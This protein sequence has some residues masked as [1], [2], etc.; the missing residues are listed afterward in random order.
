[1][2]RLFIKILVEFTSLTIWTKS[3][4]WTFAWVDPQVRQNN[5]RNISNSDNSNNNDSNNILRSIMPLR[6]F[7]WFRVRVCSLLITSWLLQYNK[8]VNCNV[9]IHISEII[10]FCLRKKNRV[11]CFIQIGKNNIITWY[12]QQSIQSKFVFSHTFF[13]V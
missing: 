9:A 8:N 5:K 10:Y 12:C 6:S 2:T 3:V 1:M 13:C 11:N 4:W 7:L